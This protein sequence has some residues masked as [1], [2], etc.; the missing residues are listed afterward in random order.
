MLA[1]EGGKGGETGRKRRRVRAVTSAREASGGCAAA[2]SGV[3]I[4][5]AAEMC[6]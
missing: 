4:S 1:A 2:R 3:S 5:G 6:V